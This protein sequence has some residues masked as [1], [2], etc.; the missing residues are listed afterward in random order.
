MRM[1]RGIWLAAVGVAVAVGVTLVALPRAP[2]WTTSSPEAL[3]EFEAGDEAQQ[4]VYLSDAL[5]HFARANEIDPDFVLA[6]YRY[7]FLLRGSNPELSEKLLAEL[8]GA[9]LDGLTARERFLVERWRAVLDGREDDAAH[10]LNDYLD[11][12]PDDPH[13][14]NLK[15]NAA[16]V[17]GYLEEAE[18]LF[19]QV[20]RVEPNWVRAYNALGYIT[21]TQG[22]FAESEEYFMGYRFIA[23][24]QANPHD[25]LGELFIT[26]GRYDEAADSLERA[27]E[28]R[29]DFFASYDHLA[30]A[31]MAVGDFDDAR[32]TIERA[33]R[34]GMPEEYV[35]R[36]SCQVEYQELK[37]NMEWRKIL[38]QRDSECVRGFAVGNA[39]LATHLAACRLGDWETVQTIEDEAAALLASKQR[40]D[41]A[42]NAALLQSRINHMKGVRLAVRGDLDLAEELLR[43]A[44]LGLT[45]METETARFKLNN[46]L[47]LVEVLF[48]AGRDADAHK[49]LFQNARA[50]PRLKSVEIVARCRRISP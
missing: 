27:I 30:T 46:R 26:T 14:L 43:A 47:V 22:R 24:D 6:K 39:A 40:D 33:R 12:Y 4:K 38:E 11:S 41:G 9:E 20:L 28:I 48:S 10:L 42:R 45:Y 49:L 37:R 7:A 2:E 19:Q 1:H 17:R 31:Q 44:D 50:R 34:E 23:P 15:A 36:L 13:A 29:P 16:W 35:F 8:A 32:D 3:A 18:R 25:S 5:E 21:M